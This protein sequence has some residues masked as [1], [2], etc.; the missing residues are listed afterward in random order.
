MSNFTNHPRI[1]MVPT[2][3]LKLDP[4]KLRIHTPRQ[5]ALLKNSISRF[6]F[7]VPIVVGSDNVVDAGNARLI[8][9]VELGLEFVPVIR[10]EFLNEN[11]RRAF[12]LAENRIAEL[13]TWDDKRLKKEL[14]HLFDGGL[15]EFTGFETKDLD[16]SVP[17]LAVRAEVT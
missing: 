4:S 7:R 6:G 13:A 9:A 12:R 10:A 15:L 17:E 8:A 11:E 5:I 14:E 2:A 1:E 3:G 16:F